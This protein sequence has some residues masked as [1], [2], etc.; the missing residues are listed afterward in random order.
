M[1][2]TK[3]EEQFTKEILEDVYEPE[4]LMDIQQ[5]KNNINV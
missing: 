2:D 1:N 4:V 5:L 3:K